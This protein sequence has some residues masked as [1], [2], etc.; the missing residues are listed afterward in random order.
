MRTM[1]TVG[2]G[3]PSASQ[4]IRMVE[5]GLYPTFSSHLTIFGRAKRKLTEDH[6]SIIYLSIDEDNIIQQNTM[7]YNT[8]QYKTIEYNT[9]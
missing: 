8:I 7:Q 3:L 2:A 4:K 1:V 6:N 9:I 5:P